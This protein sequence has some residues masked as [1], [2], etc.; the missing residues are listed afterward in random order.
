M[1][2][3]EGSE[4]SVV[5]TA[6]VAKAERMLAIAEFVGVDLGA[7]AFIAH[8]FEQRLG[9]FDAAEPARRAEL[10]RLSAEDFEELATAY[11]LLA[12]VVARGGT[13]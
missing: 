2:I 12:A 4:P 6:A 8:R 11:R 1:R 5:E 3:V 9:M 10:E 13:A 7:L